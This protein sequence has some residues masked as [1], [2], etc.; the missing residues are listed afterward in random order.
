M[1]LSSM[2]SY[3]VAKNFDDNLLLTAADVDCR[4]S[5]YYTASLPCCLISFLHLLN[6]RPARM[7]QVPCRLS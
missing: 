2:S 5:F 3:N 1:N 6:E 7:I 4:Y